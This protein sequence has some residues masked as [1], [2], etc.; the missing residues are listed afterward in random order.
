MNFKKNLSVWGLALCTSL[1][2]HAQTSAGLKDAFKDQFLIGAALNE[3][4]V[5]GRD[6]AA[7]RLIKQH[8]NAIVAENCTK[9]EVIHPEEHVYNFAPTDALVKFGED[10]GMEVIGHCLIW[11]SQLAKWFAVDDQGNPVSAKVLKK[12]M[13]EHIT[14]LVKRYKGRIHGWDVVNEA[15]IEDGSYRDTPF[16]RILGEEF[17]PWAFK[18]AHKAD[19]NVELYYNDYGMNVPGRRDAVVKLIRSLKKRGLRIDAVGMQAH[20]GMDYPD[21]REFETALEAFAAEGVKV[22]I[23]EWDMSALPT[24]SRSANIA[25]KAEYE[26][27][28]NPYPNGLPDDVSREWNDRMKQCFQLFLKH[29]DVITRVN[30]WGVTDGDSWKNDFPVHGRKEYPLLF[31]RNYQP[32]PFVK[33]LLNEKK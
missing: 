3:G 22:M 31:D 26:A 7:L 4:Q 17:I 28:L 21:F 25:D 2:V 20:M 9:S 1:S 12:R 29:A 19:P 18:C 11:H 24:V 33:D 23:T 8:F 14:T 16:Y 13:K 15:I 27:R 32:K 6:T 5:A 10:N 30:A